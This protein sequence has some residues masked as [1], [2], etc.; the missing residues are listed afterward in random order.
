MCKETLQASSSSS[1][2]PWVATG[3]RLA[4]LG[5]APAGRATCP[6]RVPSFPFHCHCYNE[7]LSEGWCPQTFQGLLRSKHLSD[8]CVWPARLTAEG[9]FRGSAASA[10][11]QRRATR[12]HGR[13]LGRVS[14]YKCSVTAFLVPS[15]E[16]TLVSFTFMV[17]AFVGATSAKLDLIAAALRCA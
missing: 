8:R 6:L 12:L 16:Q 17:T 1:R 3:L 11:G 14:V 9:P 2:G 10:G 5:L 13:G 15:V 4:G 7:E